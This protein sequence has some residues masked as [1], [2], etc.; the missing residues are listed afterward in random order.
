MAD[1][2]GLLVSDLRAVLDDDA[3][4]GVPT[5]IDGFARSVESHLNGII[6]EF[7]RGFEAWHGIGIC[8]N[9]HLGDTVAECIEWLS[10]PVREVVFERRDENDDRDWRILRILWVVVGDGL[11]RAFDQVDIAAVVGMVEHEREVGV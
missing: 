10:S 4:G 6:E 7:T 5:G 3:V 11:I 2:R 1:V 9:R 8:L